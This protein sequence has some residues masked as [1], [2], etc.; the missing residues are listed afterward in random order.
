MTEY[1]LL[2]FILIREYLHYVERKGLLEM[3]MAKDLK[4]MKEVR[5]KEPKGKKEPPSDLVPEALATDRAFDGAIKRELGREGLLEKLKDK[6]RR[7]GR[8]S[9]VQRHKQGRNP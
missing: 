4:E 6:L 3:I 7:H 8:E 1:A 2:V 9:T 5:T